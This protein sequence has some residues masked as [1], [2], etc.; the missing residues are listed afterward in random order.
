M[1]GSTAQPYPPVPRRKTQTGVTI[2]AREL[3]EQLELDPEN[4]EELRVAT[5]LR[6]VAGLLAEQYAPSAPTSMKNEAVIRHASYMH[7]TQP[8]L[9][10]RRLG[11]IDTEPVVNHA[12]AFRL[13]GSAALLSPWKVRRAGAI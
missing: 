4:E 11:I 12:A 10:L 5:R 3:A 7:Q 1:T 9:G 6:E 8:M 13:C 2:T